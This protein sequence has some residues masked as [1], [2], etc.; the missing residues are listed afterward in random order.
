[1]PSPQ[2]DLSWRSNFTP[3]NRPVLEEALETA[4]AKFKQDFE[5]P[6][7]YT[8]QPTEAEFQ[9]GLALAHQVQAALQA[10]KTDPN[11][12]AQLYR[13]CLEHRRDYSLLGA[14]LFKTVSQWHWLVNQEPQFT[15]PTFDN[16]IRISP[17]LS[18]LSSGAAPVAQTL[19]EPCEGEH[20]FERAVP[21][22]I[23]YAR[24][25]LN[26]DPLPAS[27]SSRILF[28]WRVQPDNFDLNS[29]RDS[30]PLEFIPHIL[31]AINGMLLKQLQAGNPLTGIKITIREGSYH[32]I[33]SKAHSY[34]IATMSAL[35]SAL[36]T[37]LR[38]PITPTAQGWWAKLIARLGQLLN[39]LKSLVKGNSTANH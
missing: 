7:P 24:V 17:W 11:G 38:Q 20:I 39:R 1:M 13:Q 23:H 30:I 34:E 9:A 2:L 35:K 5:T 16:P 15:S 37:A 8:E 12:T 33:D 25:G 31:S 27:Q 28:H 4:I 6:G 14:S 26:V 3:E 10:A 21:G 19:A 18:P 22:S 32:P 29:T 36:E